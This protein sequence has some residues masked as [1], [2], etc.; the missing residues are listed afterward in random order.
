M[1][2]LPVARQA[3]TWFKPFELEAEAVWE[4][5]LLEALRDFGVY[6]PR[7]HEAE[8]VYELPAYAREWFD[9]PKDAWKELTPGTA[10]GTL[11]ND[12]RM[13][14]V[15]AGE[16]GESNHLRQEGRFDFFASR[17]V[18]D[19]GLPEP[20]GQAEEPW[21]VAAT[22]RPLATEAA[23]SSPQEALHEVDKIVPAGPSRKRA[24]ELLTS[25]QND[26]RYIPTFER[27]VPEADKTVGLAYWA[28]N[29]SAAP[30]SRASRAVEDALFGLAAD[31]LDPPAGAFGISSPPGER[32]T[33][34]AMTRKRSP[35]RL[36]ETGAA[37][38][39]GEGSFLPRPRAGG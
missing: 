6:I 32:W 19:F 27:L 12:A 35:A 38:A 13:L 20:T 39:A 18:K 30:R 7:E 16:A 22:A 37:A 10:R 1:V 31:R 15:L 9:Q 4:R 5:G 36:R 28:R 3:I 17:A 8:M 26:V 34:S 24:L 11:V 14:Q 29:L 2:W 23:D 33:R 25:W 21:R